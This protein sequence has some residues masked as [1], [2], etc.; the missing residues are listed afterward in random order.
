MSYP[1]HFIVKG[2]T[3]KLNTKNPKLNRAGVPEMELDRDGKPVPVLEDSLIVDGEKVSALNG[4]GLVYLRRYESHF[5]GTVTRVE[6][7]EKPKKKKA[8]V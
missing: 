1:Y 6:E 4:H 5:P 2:D 3:S 8:D 7:V